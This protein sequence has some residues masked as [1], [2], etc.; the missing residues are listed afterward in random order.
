MSNLWLCNKTLDMS[1]GQRAFTKG[2]IYKQDDYVS[3]YGEVIKL[4]SERNKATGVT[5]GQW[6]DHFTLVDENGEEYEDE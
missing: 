1:S 6:W 4:F 5:R 3:K 2:R